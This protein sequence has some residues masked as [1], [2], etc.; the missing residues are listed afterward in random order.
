MILQKITS[1]EMRYGPYRL[2]A[3]ALC[4]MRYAGMERG[5]ARREKLFRYNG[6]RHDRAHYRSERG[7]TFG[8]AEDNLRLRRAVTD[9]VFFRLINLIR[10][11]NY[12]EIQTPHHRSSRTPNDASHHLRTPFAELTLEG[13]PI[14]FILY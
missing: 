10:K 11:S 13:K 12:K 3:E 6:R 8:K 1:W 7:Y 2:A 9:E 4:K 14:S 5:R